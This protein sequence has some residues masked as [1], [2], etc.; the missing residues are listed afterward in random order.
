MANVI[1]IKRSQVT[2]TPTSLAEGELAYSEVSDKLFIGVSGAGIDA[3]GGKSYTDKLD[4]IDSGATAGATWNSDITGQPTVVSQAEA[5]AGTA[6]TERIWTAQRVAQAI[7]ALAPASD[8]TSVFGRTGAVVA[9]SGDYD[10]SQI[11]FTP[12]GN[13]ISTDVQAAIA[14]VDNEKL[15]LAG[16]TMTGALVLSGNPAADLQAATKQYVDA[17]VG[18]LRPKAAVA[19]ATTANITLSGTQTIDGVALV[20]GDRVLVKDQTAGE[21]NGLYEVAAGAW[22]RTT[23]ADNSPSGEVVNG[24]YTYVLGGTAN[25]GKGYILTTQDPI[26]LDTTALTFEIYNDVAQ[27]PVSSVNG[28]TG[29]V[30]LTS[31]DISDTGQTN[32][33]A[34]QPELDK[35]AGIEA[36]ATAGATWGSDITG[37]P[38]IVDQATAEAG[39]STTEVMY[40]PQRVTQQIAQATLDGGSF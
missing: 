36:G 28:E 9:V 40:T 4:G 18:G 12:T 19:A 21:D 33:W 11:D 38:A 1:Q 7:A 31:D 16:G 37:Q 13:L 17:L 22:S 29:A 20:A 10:A 32:K 5:E 30:V 34:T 6:T 35:L 26:V 8:V 25:G 14:E 23:D 27:A 15:A 3:I 24:I 2:A 39:T